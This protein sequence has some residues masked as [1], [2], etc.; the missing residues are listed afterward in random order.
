MGSWIRAELV[1]PILRGAFPSFGF[2][3]SVRRQKALFTQALDFNAASPLGAVLVVA[4]L[5]DQV[6]P[7]HQGAAVVVGDALSFRE[8]GGRLNPAGM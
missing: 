3:P 1:V 4:T 8:I 7:F 6:T 5:P 2:Q